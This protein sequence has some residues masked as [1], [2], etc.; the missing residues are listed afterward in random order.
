MERS[1]KIRPWKMCIQHTDSEIAQ[2]DHCQ[3]SGV[4]TWQHRTIAN[5]VIWFGP[6]YRSIHIVHCG[7]LTG[8]G[9]THR[10]M[11]IAYMDVHGREPTGKPTVR[12]ILPCTRCVVPSRLLAQT[13]APPANLLC[14][15]KRGKAK[16]VVCSLLWTQICGTN[17]GQAK[18]VVCV[19]QCQ[20]RRHVMSTHATC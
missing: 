12:C 18:F 11:Y 20:M 8:F 13:A 10:F 16:L 19:T 17:R 5:L 14:V 15:T 7:E 2:Q 9:H 4:A 1:N 3:A 6:T